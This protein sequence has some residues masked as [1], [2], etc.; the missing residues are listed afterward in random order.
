MEKRDCGRW[1]GCHSAIAG[2]SKCCTQGVKLNVVENS[3]HVMKSQKCVNLGKLFSISANFIGAIRQENELEGESY[4]VTPARECSGTITAHCSPDLPN[5]QECRHKQLENENLGRMQWLMPVIPA[6]WEAK[7]GRSRGQE[8]ETILANMAGV[9]WRDLGSLQ[10]PPPGFKRFSCLSFLSSWEY[11]SV[12]LCPAN[13]CIFIRDQVSPRCHGRRIAGTYKFKTAV[14]CD[15]TTAPSLGDNA[16]YVVKFGLLVKSKNTGRVWWLTPV[17]QALWETE[18][19]MSQVWW[20]VPVVP[21]TWEAEAGELLEPG[22][23]R[24]QDRVLLRPERSGTIITHCS[25]NLLGSKDPSASASQVA[26]ITDDA[27]TPNSFSHVFVETGYPYIAQAVF[28]RKNEEYFI[29]KEKLGRVR[30]LTP[31]IPALWE[32][33]AGGS[34]GQEVET[35]LANMEAEAGELLEPGRQR[36]RV[37]LCQPKLECHGVIMAG[38]KR[39]PVSAFPAVRITGVRYH[40]WLIFLFLVEIGSRFVAQAELELLGSSDPLTSAS[41]RTRIIGRWGFTMLAR[42]VSISRPRDLPASASQSARITGMSHRARP[43][44]KN[45]ALLSYLGCS[46]VMQSELTATLTFWA[47]TCS[48][49]SLGSLLAMRSLGRPRWLIPGIAA[50]EVR[51]SRPAWPTS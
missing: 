37:A 16:V 47:Q 13:F 27:T 44:N 4:S 35:I 22:R 46:S 8:M 32:A 24:L 45:R 30:C 49:T 1:K 14:S 39:S 20:H 36:L 21:A 34:Q 10:P 48:G 12:P 2:K 28:R 43:H 11:R 33:K 42:M 7:A 19:K 26:G 17:I 25:L 3:R 41:Q 38:L 18:T 6:L 23:Q 51:N 31:V 15:C 50:P 9:Q 29:K 40:A 5:S